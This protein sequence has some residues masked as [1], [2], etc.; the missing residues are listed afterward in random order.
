[1]RSTTPGL[2]WKFEPQLLIL[3]GESSQVHERIAKSITV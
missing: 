2:G 3:D 1:V